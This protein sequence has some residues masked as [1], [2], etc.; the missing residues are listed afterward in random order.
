MTNITQ[1]NEMRNEKPDE[2][3]ES[4]PLQ[5]WDT[6]LDIEELPEWET[7]LEIIEEPDDDNPDS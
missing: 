6:A 4:C 2:A 5:T 7:K 3:V 1:K